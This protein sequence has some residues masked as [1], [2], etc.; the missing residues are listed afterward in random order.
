M[1][2]YPPFSAICHVPAAR[3]LPSG[4]P[5]RH[6]HRQPQQLLCH[7]WWT[8]ALAWVFVA[9]PSSASWSATANDDHPP[10]AIEVFRC[11]FDE[12]WDANYDLWP[13]RWVRQ[14]GSDYPHYVG[15]Q[16][17]DDDDAKAFG[18]RCL[19]IDLDGASAAVSSPPIRV[20]SR[21]SYLLMA[22]IKLMSVVHS[23]VT[24]TI[25]FYNT[26]GKLLQSQHSQLTPLTDGWH[27]IKITSIDPKDPTIDRA[28]ISLSVRRGAKGD[29]K[30][31][32]ALSD[33][34]LARLPRIS[35]S[36]NIPFNVYSDPK[37][38]VVNCDLS[39]IGR[40]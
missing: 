24:L 2:Q 15:V 28:V 8:C 20:I 3:P 12:S 16:I 1:N 27:Q 18:G 21:F 34:W 36:T 22:K 35:V 31:H 25:D 32:V 13:D 9:L 11:T 40:A 39:E 14:S 6:C 37:D 38:V 5:W 19:E 23:D 29:L 17:R 26:A 10:D 33:V 7:I 4:S 30:G